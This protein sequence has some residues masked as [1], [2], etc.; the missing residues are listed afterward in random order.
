MIMEFMSAAV[1]AF[2]SLLVGGG[3]GY[4]VGYS[5]GKH[6]GKIEGQIDDLKDRF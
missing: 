6:P 1:W 4:Y 5:R 3:I 2:V